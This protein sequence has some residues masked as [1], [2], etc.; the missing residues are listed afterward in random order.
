ME[1][2]NEILLAA[3]RSFL[4]RDEIDK[5][6]S[7]LD[8]I[9]LADA[10]EIVEELEDNER[11]NIFQAWE[12]DHSAGALLEMDEKEQV[13][14]AESL[15][16]T[17][18][19][20]I[21]EE[22]PSDDA[23]DLLGDLS[24]ETTEKILESME[25]KEAAGVRNL[26]VYGK[27]TAGGLMTPDFVALDKNMTA[28]EAIDKLRTI[29][30]EVENIFYVFVANKENQLSGVISL[31]DLVIARP[32]KTVKD[33]MKP[34]VIY[35][36]TTTDQEEVAK[37]MAKYDLLALPVIDKEHHLLG[38][39][40]IDDVVDVIEEE[41]TED[42][43]K[44]SG[45]GGK[46]ESDVL[47]DSLSTVV[48]ARIPWLLI[49]LLGEVLIVGF[50][51]SRFTGL[52]AAVPALVIYWACMTSVGG[53]TSFQAS[54]IAVRGLATGDIEPKAMFIRVLYEVRLGLILGII[55]AVILF[56][57]ALFWQKMLPLAVTLAVAN[58]AIVVSGALTGAVA[59]IVF[60]RLGID[61]AVASNPFLAMVMDAL[62]LL[63]YF[64]IA[65]AI[66]KVYHVI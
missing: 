58:I 10:A 5:A 25:P 42:M 36:E 17:L 23:A 4:R 1:K 46:G 63:L 59:P 20:D 50:V 11:K 13:D 52:L 49:A 48:K 33:I 27:Q 43:Y 9:H 44:M 12:P 35:T 21:L 29:A 37:I 64:V 57:V 31:R 2:R 34:D 7:V 6:I 55:M 32:N 26:L 8:K 18:I 30:P 3:V 56:I 22:M 61:P 16:T 38:M 45:T 40:T 47:E 19:S 14:V 15:S 39:V 41:A 51:A 53:N 62:S 65:T 24:Y 66:L 28:Q 60:D 54:T